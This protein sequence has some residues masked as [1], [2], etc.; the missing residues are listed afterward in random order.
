MGAGGGLGANPA[1]ALRLPAAARIPDSERPGRFLEPP[2]H[3]KATGSRV[4]ALRPAPSPP[5]C[6]P[7]QPLTSRPPSPASLPNFAKGAYFN[8]VLVTNTLFPPSLAHSHQALV[9][10]SAFTLEKSKI[11]TSE[12][13]CLKEAMSFP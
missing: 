10:R 1:L 9:T 3:A 11:A 2:I 5:K 7:P 6:R 13:T 4:P 8:P 12:D